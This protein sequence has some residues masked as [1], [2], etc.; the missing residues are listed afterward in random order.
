METEEA[1]VGG[2]GLKWD[3]G[4]VTISFFPSFSI[5]LIPLL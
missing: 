5:V 4:R 2:L 3:F 1:D